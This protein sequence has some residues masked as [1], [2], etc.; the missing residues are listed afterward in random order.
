[1]AGRKP[2]N[3]EAPL[4]VRR[5]FGANRVGQPFDWI[6]QGINL[7]RVGQLF[8]TG[9]VGH[10]EGEQPAPAVEQAP[11]AVEVAE[12]DTDTSGV[13]YE[14]TG[15]GWYNVLVDGI[16]ANDAKIKGREAA[17]EWAKENGL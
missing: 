12:A 10:S 9:Y 5:R 16:Q 17:E 8:R 7:R 6:A 2:F 4:V 15:A 1:M 13:T 14:H 11:V 3:P